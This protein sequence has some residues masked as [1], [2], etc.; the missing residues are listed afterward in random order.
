MS[1]MSRDKGKVGEREVAALLRER[2]IEAK[3]G[4]QHKGGAGSPDVIADMPGIHLEV[5]RTEALSLYEAMAQA[6]ADAPVDA[7]PVLVHRRNGKRWLAIMDF[8][9]FISLWE[10]ANGH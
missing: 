1:K 5:K 3:R 7:R 4:V 2:G 8:H 6:E 9:D 10:K